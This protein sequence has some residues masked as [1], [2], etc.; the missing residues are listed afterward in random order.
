[1]QKRIGTAMAVV[2]WGV[3]LSIGVADV[4]SMATTGKTIGEKYIWKR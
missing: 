4:A 2:G 1:M 3:S